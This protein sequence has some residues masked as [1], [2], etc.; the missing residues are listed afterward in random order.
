M[1]ACSIQVA[2]NGYVVKEASVEQ[3][4]QVAELANAATHVFA[5]IDDL[6]YWLNLKLDT[7]A[8]E[9]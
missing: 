2:V 1:K 3:N 6:K 7:P 5:N 4:G 8:G 9:E